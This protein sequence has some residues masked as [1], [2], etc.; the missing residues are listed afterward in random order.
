MKDSAKIDLEESV[1]YDEMEAEFHEKMI[2][3]PNPLRR[4]F[5]N[6]K[7]Q[8]L[9]KTIKSFY[10]KKGLIVDLGCGTVNWNTEKLPVLG[11]DQ[12]EK[13]LL[14]AKQEERLQDFRVLPIQQ[15]GLPSKSTDLVVISEVLEHI[16]DYPKA[17]QEIH[18]ILKTNGIC[19]ATVPYDTFIS[20][21]K[22]FF[23]L[24]CFLRGTLKGEEYF[25]KGAGHVNHFSPKTIARAFEENGFRVEKQFD[26]IR[27]TIF[28]VVR[29]VSD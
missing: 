10:S 18:R 2:N 4:W 25:K 26:N 1:H 8:L 19:I 29:K 28:T 21:W 5:H 11:I 20:F 7:N 17:I 12:N 3:S 14:K 15:T 16:S 6:S 27:F 22:P 23:A 24:Q 13:M 9:L